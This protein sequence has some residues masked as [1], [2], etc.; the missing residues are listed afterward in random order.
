MS[1]GRA[2]CGGHSDLSAWETTGECKNVMPTVWAI[3][4]E[5]GLSF[6]AFQAALAPN[7]TFDRGAIL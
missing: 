2:A 1:E 7:K 5:A 3:Q 6:F 4:F